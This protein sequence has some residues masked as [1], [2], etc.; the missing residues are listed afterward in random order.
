MKISEM[1]EE[2]VRDYA[3]KLEEEKTAV[4]EQLA[5]K[6]TQIQE[7]RELNTALQKRNNELF[8]KVEQQVLPSAQ[9]EPTP[10]PKLEDLANKISKEIR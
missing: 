3:L 10:V 1:T 6:D 4:A 8:L 9:E 7:M 2:E 5:Q